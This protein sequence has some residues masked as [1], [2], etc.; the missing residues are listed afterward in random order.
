VVYYEYPQNGQNLRR[1]MDI[2][3]PQRIHTINPQ[4]EPVPQWLPEREP[5]QI[6]QDEPVSIPQ[7]VG[8]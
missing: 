4:Q 8:E 6:P 7:K 2:G 3:E 1:L 5:M